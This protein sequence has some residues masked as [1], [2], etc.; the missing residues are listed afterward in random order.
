[1][2]SRIS[3]ISSNHN[4]IE[5]VVMFMNCGGS[6]IEGTGPSEKFSKDSCFEEGDV[7]ETG[8]PIAGSGSYTA[9]YQSARYG[10]FSYKIDGITPGQSTRNCP[11]VYMI[12]LV[13]QCHKAVAT[14]MG[15]LID[16]STVQNKVRGTLIAR[17]KN[18]QLR[19]REISAYTPNSEECFNELTEKY[20]HDKKRWAQTLSDLERKIKIMKEEQAKLSEEAHTYVDSILDLDKMTE[21]V[22]ALVAQGEELKSKYSEEMA[23]SRRL[24][25]ELQ[26]SKGI[27]VLSDTL[28][29]IFL[30]NMFHSICITGNIRVFCRCRPLNKDEMSSGYKSNSRF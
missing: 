5:N 28:S 13:L 26:E 7:I 25:N 23:R 18:Y 30:P 20:Q 6:E 19:R 24:F 21:A 8:E 16:T 12:F 2:Q 1:M 14:K 29:C 22:Q 4:A 10:A 17:Y 27:I 15:D 11:G 3:D 9:L